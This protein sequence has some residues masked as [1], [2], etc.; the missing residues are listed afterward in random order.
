MHSFVGVNLHY[1][2]FICFVEYPQ[3]HVLIALLLFCIVSLITSVSNYI[4]FDTFNK[5][6]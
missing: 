1:G 5:H 3:Y 4:F 6:V 2:K